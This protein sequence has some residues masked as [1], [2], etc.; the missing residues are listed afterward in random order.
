[1]AA[2]ILVVDDEPHMQDLIRQNFRREIRNG[3]Y[4]F[5]FALSG[6]AALEVLADDMPPT[7]V[8]VLSDINMPGM[9]GIQ[10]LAKIRENWPGIAV[11]MITAYGNR[12]TE[13][14]ARALGAHCFL[15]KPI[16]FGC[17]RDNLGA[18]IAGEP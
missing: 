14:E 16:D 18:A 1:M 11:F 8:M 2:R 4:D 17:L 5:D 13:V 12:A 7:V 9:S 15:A 3:V 10:L 6:E